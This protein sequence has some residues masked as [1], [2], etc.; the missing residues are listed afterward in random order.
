MYQPGPKAN[1]T[2]T[3]GSPSPS[4]V[5][6]DGSPHNISVSANATLI[7]TEPASSSTNRN[8]FAGGVTFITHLV[9]AS[10]TCA[11]WSFTNYFQ[12]NDTYDWTPP[13]ACN[14]CASQRPQVTI[15]YLGTPTTYNLA[16]SDGGNTTTTGLVALWMTTNTVDNY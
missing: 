12:D 1:L 3:G 7:A 13:I 2:L 9:C 11:T 14:S 6:C 4:S 10:G 8:V 15:S 5:L 16:A